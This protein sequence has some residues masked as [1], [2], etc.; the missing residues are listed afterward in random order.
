MDNMA[1]SIALSYEIILKLNSKVFAYP[2]HE[3]KLSG[4]RVGM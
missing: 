4:L 3:M 2:E 1:R